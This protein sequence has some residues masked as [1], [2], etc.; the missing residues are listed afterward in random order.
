[1]KVA[2]LGDTHFGAIM[3][4]GKPTEDGSNTRIKDYE[5]SMDFCVQYCIENKIDAFVQTGDLF[6]KRNPSPIE[7]EAA[8]KAIRKLSSANIPTFIIMGNHDYKRFGGTY[9]SAL[10]SMPAKHYTNVRILIEPD[11]ISVSNSS[12]ER[13]NLLL[14]PFRDKRMYSGDTNIEKS[15]AFEKHILTLFEGCNK[16]Y[17]TIFVGH[18]FF[19]EGSYSDFGGSE[20]LVNPKTFKD[21]SASFMGHYHAQKDIDPSINCYYTGSMERT[22]F[23]EASHKKYLFVYDTN[24]MSVN[25]VEIPCRDLN[26]ISLDLSQS[27]ISEVLKELE[28]SVNEIDV[29]EKIVRMKISIQQDM[30]SLI[31]KGLLEEKLYK[32]GAYYVSKIHIENKFRK[33]ARDTSALKE[34]TDYKIF[35]KFLLSQK[36]PTE[37]CNKISEQAKKIME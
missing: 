36:L 18:N 27:E 20:L 28:N 6:E 25:K 31:K 32:K 11:I 2:I 16:K 7:I 17:P 3:G 24:T 35:Q 34:E 21:F 1:M 22:N 13:V 37:L 4:L 15:L 19:Y 10:L 12:Y 5:K 23:G 30:N 29:T 14:M 9:T 26:E 33:I 8:D